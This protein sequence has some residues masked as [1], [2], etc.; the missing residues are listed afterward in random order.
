MAGMKVTS[1][2]ARTAHSVRCVALS[3][4][5]MLLLSG[6]EKK[7]GGQ[8][9]AVVNSEEITQPEIRAEAAA[10]GVSPTQDFQSYAPVVLERVIERNLLADYARKQGL[11][12]GPE[13]V[14]RRRQLEQSL[15]ATLALQKLTGAQNAPSAADVTAFINKNPAVFANRERLTLDQIRFATPSDVTKI[16]ALTALGSVSAIEAKLKADGVKMAR[17]NA[18]LD[19]GT[20]ETVV[21]KQIVAVPDGQ[22]F[23]LSI[24]GITYI[25]AITARTPAATPPASWTAPAT[26]MLRREGGQKAAIDAMA[27]LHKDA[28]IQ[29]DP[30]FKPA[31]PPTAASKS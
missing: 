7:P 3:G 19:T 15:L 27:K 9:I 2:K 13:Y 24:N 5:A 31:T 4:V 6:C 25:S 1:V 11:D 18:V 30:A 10:A 20:V 17:G 8:V 12:R 22:V 16:K 28:N 26:A 14:A 29:Y 23:D 21:A